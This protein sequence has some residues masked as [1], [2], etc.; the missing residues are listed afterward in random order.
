M[1]TRS[2]GYKRWPCELTDDTMQTIRELA[3]KHNTSNLEMTRRLI[4]HAI[5]CPFFSPDVSSGRIIQPSDQG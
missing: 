2:R 5:N 4:L 1:N 3:N